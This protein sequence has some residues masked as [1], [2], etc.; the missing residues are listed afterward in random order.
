MTDSSAPLPGPVPLDPRT[1]R[2]RYVTVCALFWLPLGLAIAPMVALMTE[3][4]LA[5]AAVA[6]CV[7]AHSLTAAALELPTGGLSDV[8][9]RRAVLAAAGLFDL[10]GLVLHALGTT[11]WV[12]AL[13]MAL[14]GAGRAL[15]SGPAEAWYVDTVHASAGPDAELRTGLARGGA[16][17]SAALAAG[18][19]IGGALPWLLGLGS[20]L[21]ARLADATSGLV[22]PLSVPALLGAVVEIG[23]LAYVLIALPEPPR[24]RTTLRGV[25]RGVPATVVAGV[26]L[27]GRDVLVRRIV[28][29]AGAAGSALVTVEVLTPGRAVDLTGAPES[30]AVLFAGLA[31]AGYLCSMAGSHLGPPLARYAGGSERAVLVGL[32]A[33]AGGLLL[34]GLTAVASGP[35]PLT[36]AVLGY[37]LVYVGLGAAGPSE[38]DILHR[39]VDSSGRATALSVQSLSLQLVGAGTGLVIGHLPQGS[40]RWLLGGAV[41][42]AG[43]LLWVRR[44]TAV[45]DATSVSSAKGAGGAGGTA[46]A[47]DGEAAR[48]VTA[49]PDP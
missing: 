28:L 30:G 10:V 1:A 46:D 49:T 7:A 43:A 22:I 20:D 9:G 47:G 23:F 2:R 36:L 48:P 4:G 14:K 18:V 17:T 26:R 38:N 12:L 39:R 19:L 29:S 13:G 44:R 3:R 45:E 5:L 15:S 8:L 32:G 34:L 27:G 37:A 6:G 24:R 21:G 25:L 41:L 40:P 42:L 31:C 33:S 16:A 35:A 11:A